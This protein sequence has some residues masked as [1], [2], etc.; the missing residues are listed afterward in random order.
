[1]L[2]SQAHIVPSYTEIVKQ[3]SDDNSHAFVIL[4]G[5]VGIFIDGV[6]VNLLTVGDCVGEAAILHDHKRNASCITFDRAELL[7]FQTQF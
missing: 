7:L 6:F 3:N 5:K 2:T 1:M 4:S